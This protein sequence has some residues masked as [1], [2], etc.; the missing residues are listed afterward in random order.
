MKTIEINIYKFNEL[1]KTIQQKVID[2]FRYDDDYYMF[3]D[4]DI[5]IIKEF[6]EDFGVNIY[7]YSLSPY[8]HSYI[9]YNFDN[10]DVNNI[11]LS[12]IAK[13]YIIDEMEYQDSDEYIKETIELN[14]YDFTKDGNIH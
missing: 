8:S 9:K 2:K 6:A 3:I 13:K 7:D 11:N 10:Y 5:K 12:E 4:D 14:D 1:E